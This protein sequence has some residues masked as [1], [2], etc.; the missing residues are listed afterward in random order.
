MNKISD[1]YLPLK[2][3]TMMMSEGQ[4]FKNYKELCTF[5]RQ[6]VADGNS[7]KSQ[8]K[9]FERHFE[10]ERQ[11]YKYIIKHIYDEPLSALSTG[12]YSNLIQ[13]LILDMMVKARDNGE[14]KINLS[15]S[16][17]LEKL[18]MVNFNYTKGKYDKRIFDD[19][20]VSDMDV[21][22]F[23]MSVDNNMKRRIDSALNSLSKKN[24]IDY[25]M[26]TMI[27]VDYDGVR[28]VR[29][30]YDIER[31]YIS[32]VKYNFMNNLGCKDEVEILL[33]GLWNKYM[34]QVMEYVNDNIQY[35][36][37]VD[38]DRVE[39]FYKA[40]DIVFHDAVTKE[41][42]MLNQFVLDNRSDIEK[43][44]NYEIVTRNKDSYKKIKDKYE[45]LLINME[46][47]DYFTMNPYK[48]DTYEYKSSNEYVEG[49]CKLVDFTIKR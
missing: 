36:I 42:S 2:T 31:Q 16:M 37:S 8:L 9:E 47:T 10:Y 30:A 35:D 48:R 46:P 18:C 13:K 15:K 14:H 11:G 20:E 24:I 44:L 12:L 27:C 38:Y 26:I 25:D 19:I 23:Y 17:L 49:G 39:Y 29:K 5:L 33:K 40:Y 3:S 22:L 21:K 32:E 4:V 34:K 6:P 43:L 7:K 45:D 41:S 1:N 28:R